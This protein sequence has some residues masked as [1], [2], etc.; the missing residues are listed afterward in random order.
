[1]LR[2]ALKGIRAELD[3]LAT[4]D[5]PE[6]A[7]LRTDPSRIL[8]PLGRPDSWQTN[9]LRSYPPRTLLLM[10]RQCGKS[11]TAAALALRQALLRPRTLTLLLSPSQRQSGE[12]FKDKVLRLY[13]ALGRPVPLANPRDN[14]LRLELANGSRIVSLPGTEATIRGYSNVALLV[15]D[16]AARVPDG[17]YLSVRPFLATSGGHLV[18]LSSAWARQGWFYDAWSGTTPWT[19][20]CVRSDQCPRIPAAFLA[21]ERRE[22]G[23]RWYAMEYECEFGDAVAAVFAERD[24]RAALTE[25][26]PLFGGPR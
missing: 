19:R 7:A 24:I 13:N 8:E 18:A 12:L 10:G 23:P 2:R 6:L 21:E 20:I 17:L 22:L 14:A 15:I 11:T 25:A 1:M 9:L 3:K 4:A 26:P 5:S 16:E